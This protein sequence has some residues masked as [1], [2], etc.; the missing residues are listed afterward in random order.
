MELGVHIVNFTTPGG[1]AG[2]GR[3]LAEI[4]RAA[5]AAGLTQLSLMD[6]FFQLQMLGGAEQPM[7]EGY[8]TLGYLA[9]HT[10]RLRLGLVVSGVTY[11]HPGILAKVATTLD[12]LSGGRA[13][14]G[15]GAA[16]YEE[17]HTGLGVP[18]PGLAERFERL[19]E[20]IQICLQMW[21]END[22]AYSGRHY[23]LAS[24][25]NI[26]QPLQRPRP[27]LLIG[28]GGERKT[29]RL[30]AQ[31]ADACNLTTQEGIPGFRHKLEVLRGHCDALGR[32]YDEIQKTVLYATAIPESAKH[33]AFID[34][35]RE[36]A[37]AGADMMIV[38]PLGERP[39]EELA[40]LSDVANALRDA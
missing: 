9:A 19:E 15:L 30:V 7:L 4:A 11:R 37:S 29:L 3:D 20:T 27:P 1:P 18:F 34:E 31:Y 13:Y 14:L 22:G 33:G 12:L 6:H 39:A 35:L 25:R 2:L 23:Q 32:D 26:P 8:T 17:E 5:E 10:Q 16:W 40:G 38:M 36:Y 21:S 28:G 24:T